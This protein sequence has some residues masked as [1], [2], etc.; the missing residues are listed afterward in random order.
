MAY[1]FDESE[2]Y[3]CDMCGEGY[4]IET[5]YKMDDGSI[6]CEDCLREIQRRNDE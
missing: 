1:E 5:M 6:V 2:M 3:P 4:P